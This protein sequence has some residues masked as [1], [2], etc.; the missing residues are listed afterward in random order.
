[1]RIKENFHA[2]SESY[3]DALKERVADVLLY[4]SYITEMKRLLAEIKKEAVNLRTLFLT[5]E[6]LKE[7]S[8]ALSYF[9]ARVQ[10]TVRSTLRN[11]KGYQQY[12]WQELFDEGENDDGGVN[13]IQENR[14]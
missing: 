6:E 12:R 14:Q 2:G 11:L 10:E 8:E 1:M 3:S 4:T 13:P 5:E 7:R 9:N